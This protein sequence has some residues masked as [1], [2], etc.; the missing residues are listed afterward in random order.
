MILDVLAWFG[1]L[2]LIL[3][4][5]YCAWHTMEIWIPCLLFLGG[6]VF[7]LWSVCRVLG[8]C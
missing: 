3:L 6:V 8:H 2:W 1:V 4:I 7:M 5:L